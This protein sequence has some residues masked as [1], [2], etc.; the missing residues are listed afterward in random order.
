MRAASKKMQPFFISAVDSGNHARRQD[1]GAGSGA[2]IIQR[3]NNYEHGYEH[4][5]DRGSG[6]Q[7]V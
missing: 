1:E 3:S 6:T 2:E 4:G 7:F 5:H